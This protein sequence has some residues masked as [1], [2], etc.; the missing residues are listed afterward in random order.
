MSKHTIRN[1]IIALVVI[2]GGYMIISGDGVSNLLDSSGSGVPTVDPFQK[3]TSVTDEQVF[4]GTFTLTTVATDLSDPAVSYG[5]DTEF[6][7]ICYKDNGS[8]D[9]L[10]WTP[11]AT[12]TS[13][14]P[15][16]L[17]IPVTRGTE[18]EG[19]L[20][21]MWCDID[22]GTSQDYYVDKASLISDNV[23]VTKAIWVDAN[24]DNV[25]GW[26]YNYNLI[27]IS[28]ADPNTAPS[29]TVF[30]RLIDE[31]SLDVDSPASL[32]SVG[33]GSVENR[34]KWSMDMDNAGDGEAL[35]QIQIRF[36][37]TDDTQWFENLSHI[38]VPGLGQIKL[39][40]FDRS[41]L[42]STTVYKYTLGSDYSTGNMLFT[43]K[44]GDTENDTPVV[45]QSNF[46]ASAEALCIEL[47]IRTVDAQGAFTTNADDV[48]IVENG[49]NTE[50][51]SL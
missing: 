43:G 33:Q 51:C 49:T 16:V 30:Y 44:T 15:E 25:D 40:E 24:D 23:R 14:N 46:D 5:G 47:Q 12:G 7:T 6:D 4:G 29:D 10:Q 1:V 38:T 45:I 26:A 19:G 21:E 27:G 22:I 9:P 41:D 34:I 48:E 3:T 39:S 32:L 50:E 37:S 11:L 17:T 35:N 31:G 42:A 13:A 2:G 36:N 18:A 28:N 8:A 20:T